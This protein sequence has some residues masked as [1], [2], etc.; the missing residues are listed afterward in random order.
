MGVCFEVHFEDFGVQLGVVE[1]LNTSCQDCQT[2]K[3]RASP[4]FLPLWCFII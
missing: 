4:D 3:G 2:V 1:F